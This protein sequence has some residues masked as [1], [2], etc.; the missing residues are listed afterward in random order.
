MGGE[1]T[2]LGNPSPCKLDGK[3]TED[4]ILDR[5]IS[6][7]SE[8]AYAEFFKDTPMD[9]GFVDAQHRDDEITMGVEA[10]YQGENLK[11]LCIHREKGYSYLETG[12]AWGLWGSDIT[13]TRR[14]YKDYKRRSKFI[15]FVDRWH[16]KF[17]TPK[18]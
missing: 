13:S 9:L 14:Y 3:K 17:F 12:H 18:I 8:E 4:P 5:L 15:K 16:A 6:I 2:G 11:I 1:G 10:T 7:V